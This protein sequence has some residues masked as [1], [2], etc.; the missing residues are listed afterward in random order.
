[1]VTPNGSLQKYNPKSGDITTISKGMP[2]DKHDPKRLNKKS[3]D[4]E[5]NVISGKDYLDI[6]RKLLYEEY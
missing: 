5:W 1:M 6:N 3:S 4:I 2:S